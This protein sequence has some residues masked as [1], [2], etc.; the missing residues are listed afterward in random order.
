[1]IVSAGALA[2]MLGSV[3]LTTSACHHHRGPAE[4]AGAKVDRAADKTGDVVE[5]GAHKTGEAI[6]DT[7]RKVNRALPGD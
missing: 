4:R 2:L 7:G 1:M 3:A 5:R 6:E